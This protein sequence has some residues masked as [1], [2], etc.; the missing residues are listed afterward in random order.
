MRLGWFGV[1]VVLLA[2]LMLVT[3]ATPSNPEIQYVRGERIRVPVG[4][5]VSV[6]TTIKAV[7]GPIS[8]TL[9]VEIKKDVV[10]WSD[11]I[12]KTLRKS[13][14]ANN[15]E[16]KVVDMGQF[17]AGDKTCTEVGCVRHYFVK[18]YFNDKVIY[19]PTSPYMRESVE[20]Y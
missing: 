17:I 14:T 19:D 7:N 4:E 3:S 20:T 10:G 16:V 5:I 1:L 18:I 12:H 6:H 15:G 9:K 11:S 2:A 8:G 13:I